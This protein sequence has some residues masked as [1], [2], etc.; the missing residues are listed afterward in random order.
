MASSPWRLHGRYVACGCR[1]LLWTVAG[2][3]PT[4]LLKSDVETAFA[5]VALE[6]RAKRTNLVGPAERVDALIQAALGCRPMVERVLVADDIR[7][8]T[9]RCR[10]PGGLPARGTGVLLKLFYGASRSP[11]SPRPCQRG[12]RTRRALS[13]WAGVESS[14]L[15]TTCASFAA[16][17]RASGWR[18][19]EPF[20]HVYA[21]PL[22]L[23]RARS[24]TIRRLLV[25]ASRRSIA[26]AISLG[27]DSV[28]QRLPT[29]W[30]SPRRSMSCNRASVMSLFRP[31]ARAAIVVENEPGSLPSAARRRSGRRSVRRSPASGF[32]RENS[33]EAA[34]VGTSSGS[35][36]RAMRPADRPQSALG[37]CRTTR[38][39][40]ARPGEQSQTD[41]IRGRSDTRR[42]G[43]RH[44]QSRSDP[45]HSH[46]SAFDL[47]HRSSR[48]TT[49]HLSS[50]MRA[51]RASVTA[52]EPR[53]PSRRADTHPRH[54][55]GAQPE[56]SS[57][58][59][60]A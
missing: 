42:S 52:P 59:R 7:A 12:K 56:P 16:S 26:A 53:T 38:P 20:A 49:A 58:R 11:Q 51:L 6:L 29:R 39:A 33:F 35:G 57:R 48:T 46:S 40:H 17:G 5:E 55:S 47:H 10:T 18:A 27:G 14:G 4:P 36:L 37:S 1:R 15:L 19:H 31:A 25:R 30:S 22:E 24:L 2:A 44:A 60:A 54:F 34:G 50:S 41:A 3:L 21:G 23:T 8:E 9:T 43:L 13:A 32:G 45:Q 28:D